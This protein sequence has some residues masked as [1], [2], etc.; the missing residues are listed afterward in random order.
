MGIPYTNAPSQRRTHQ[1]QVIPGREAEMATNDAGGVGFVLDKWGMLD[2]FLILGAEG[3]TYYVSKDKHVE[4]NCTNLISCIKEDGAR[5]VKVLTDVSTAGRAAK[6]EHAVFALA[7]VF[8]DGDDAAKKA[9][10]LVFNNV[11]RIGTDL[12]HFCTYI[13]AFGSWGRRLRRTVSNWYLLKEPT[14]LAYQIGK[15]QQRDGFAHLDVLRLAHPSGASQAQID[16]F[17]HVKGEEI[18]FSPFPIL[19]GML[20]I[21]EPGISVKKAAGI[22]TE[23]RLTHEMIPTELKNSKEIWDAL[24]PHMPLTALIRNLG[25]LTEIGLLAPLSTALKAVLSKLGDAEYI[26]KSRIHPMAALVAMKVYSQGRG[27]KGSLVWSPNQKIVDA[28]DQ[29]FYTSF[30]FVE[31]IGKPMLLALDISGSMGWEAVPGLP[32]NAR[33][34]SACM[35]MVTARV[36]SDYHCLG[37]SHRLIDLPV[38]PSQRL[39]DV[40]KTISDLPFGSTDCSLPMQWAT[41]NAVKGIGGFAVYTDNETYYGNI[42]PSQALQEYRRKHGPGAKLAVVATSSSARTIADPQ[43]AGM[44]DVVGFDTATPGVMSEFFRS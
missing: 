2:R 32:L 31:P 1:T 19:N 25:K 14:Q 4:R 27:V 30:G 11:V 22:I 41:A 15:Y 35:M 13:Q 26:Q 37:F 6:N 16:L 34:V 5:V 33:E 38:S 21:K 20:Q 23:F 12:F 39:N 8:T 42:H 43:D 28:L 7:R 3:G 10:E 17:K 24:L 9:A 29:V 36:E 44:L 40:I 18:N